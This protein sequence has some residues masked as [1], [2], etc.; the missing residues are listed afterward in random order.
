MKRLSVLLMCVALTC[1]AAVAQTIT[2]TVTN[3]TTGKPAAGTTVTLVDPMAGMAEVA[4]AKSD[5][6]GNFSIKAEAAKGPRLAK[7]ER[8]GVSYFKMISPGVATVDLTVYDASPKVEGIT[9]S[10]DVLKMQADGS[11]LQAAELFAVQNQSNPP[12]SL[13]GEHTFEFVLPEGAVIDDATAQGPN[14]QPI[15]ATTAPLGAKNHYAFSYAL[16]PGETRFQVSYH[17]PYGGQASFTPQLT[18]NYQHYVLMIPATM[19]FQARNAQKYKPMNNQP[20]ATVQ[21]VVQ[22]RE[23]DDL[24]YTLS[25]QGIFQD[26]QQQAAGAGGGGAMGG[27]QDNR[28]GGGLGRPEDGPDALVKYRWYILAALMVVLIGGGIW[29]RE[30][31]LQEAALAGGGVMSIPAASPEEIAAPVHPR[32]AAGNVLSAAP[33]SGEV[34][35]AALREELFALEVEKQKGKL[36]EAEYAKSRAALEETLRRVLNRKES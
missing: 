27:A 1:A 17:L 2:G 20:G 26:D 9:G 35:L 30:H 5:A 22:A 28:P 29:T 34:L 21:V 25:G 3:A 14:G 6:R 12:R 19:T 11:T 16:K 33:N 15:S 18:T 24:A 4:S 8:G 36:P 10:A 31:T 23:G 32:Q 13:T 7:A